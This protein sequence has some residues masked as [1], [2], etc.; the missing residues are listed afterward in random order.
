[1]L[2]KQLSAIALI[3]L[4]KKIVGFSEDDFYNNLL[5]YKNELGILIVD[6]SCCIYYEFDKYVYVDW[7]YADTFKAK[8]IGIQYLKSLGKPVKICL[9]NKN[10]YINH[11]KH[12]QD[13]YYWLALGGN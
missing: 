7:T 12:I 11:S 8:R 13:K 4:L 10:F 2:P 9:A 3:P 1:M 6:N 5:L